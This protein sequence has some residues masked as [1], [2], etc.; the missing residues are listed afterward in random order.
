MVTPAGTPGRRR[1]RRSPAGVYAAVL[2][3]ALAAAATAYLARPGARQPAEA[4]APAFTLPDTDGRQVSLAALRGKPVV[5]VFFRTFGCGVC[6]QQL[7][8]LQDIYPEIRRAGGELLAI[9]VRPLDE[10]REGRANLGLG[11]PVL[12]DE[13]TDVATSYG[14]FNLLGDELA[15]PAVFVVDR[16]GRIAWRYVGRSVA[17]RPK[18]ATVLR[19]LR[20]AA[21]AP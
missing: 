5:L 1:R 17:D 12:S 2:V 21:Q 13:T 18:A 15:A 8:E 6:Q 9:S 7:V 14:V 4:A 16:R 3:L 19:Q 11:Y 20:T 10:N